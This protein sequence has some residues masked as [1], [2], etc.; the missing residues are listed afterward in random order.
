MRFTWDAR[1]ALQNQKKHGVS[2]DEALSVFRD[3]TAL[4]FDDDEHSENEHRELAI[5]KSSQSRLL[6]V[7]FTERGNVVRIIV[8]EK[9][10]QRNIEYMKK[11]N[12][13][14]ASE[15]GDMRDH[16]DFDYSKAKPNRF[17]DQ[18]GEDTVVVVLDADVASAFPT[19]EA[20][21]EALRLVM[22]L[23]LIPATKTPS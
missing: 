4:I 21:N 17:A 23:S 10:I 19:T 8:R 6:I 22:Q 13:K 1:K 18:F 7:S 9:Q 5:G 11:R 20:V 16:Y 15:S 12:D 2:F 3:R 14:M